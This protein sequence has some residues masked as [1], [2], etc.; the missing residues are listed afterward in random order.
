MTGR[1][2]PTPPAAGSGA[3]HACDSGV[4]PCPHNCWQKDYETDLNIES[5]A[6]YFKI[7]RSDGTENPIVAPAGFKLKL[8]LK[9]GTKAT[10]TIRFKVE[11][12]AGVVAADVA[13]AKRKLESGV[14]THW[15]GK[16]TL[17]INDPVCGRKSLPIDYKVEWVDAGQHF[18]I[19]VHT[20][21]PREG[22]NGTTMHV[23]KTT[24]DWTYAHEV[25]HCFGL[26]DEYSYTADTWSV[27]YI[28]PDASLDSAINAP[29]D[30]KL[31]TA[32]DATIMSAVNNTTTL[33]RHAWNVAI[34]AQTL[35]GGD[36]GRTVT[37]SIR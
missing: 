21:Y 25:A 32:P 23:S 19:Q 4:T 16:F 9:T 35:I 30:G 13:A 34:E 12:Q 17:D 6:R 29:P 20:T 22:V 5:Y 27:K 11:P 14:A 28:K 18:V 24:T 31:R 3:G 15:T 36:V 1:S 2:E 7:F 37:C 10:L 33:P 8:P 26:P